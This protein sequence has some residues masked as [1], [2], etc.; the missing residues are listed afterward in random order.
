MAWI[1]VEASVRTHEKFLAAGPAACWLWLCGLAYCQ[2]GLTDGFIPF[3]ALSHLGVKAPQALKCKLVTVGLWHDVEG[4]WE[5]HGYLKHNKA[6]K[7]IRRIQ[8]ERR[9]SGERGGHASGA[10]RAKQVAEA[11]AKQPANPS[12]PEI[13]STTSTAT[14]TAHAEPARRSA[15]LVI[16]PIKHAHLA[17]FSPCGDVPNQLHSEF[18]RKVVNGG[19][20]ESEANRMVRDFYKAVEAE[21]VGQIV[22]ENAFAFWRAQFQAKGKPTA[23]PMSEAASM[24]FQTL[25][26]GGPK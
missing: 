3:A 24:V 23:K 4:G 11:T 12:T 26:M 21:H 20:D 25:N 17:H 14:A 1:K 19:A 7:E 15:T 2:E 13:S 18:V 22:A 16:P 8:G 5:V 9:Q 6:E 10:S